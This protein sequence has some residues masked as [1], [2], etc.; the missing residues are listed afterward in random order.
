M[1]CRHGPELAV[2]PRPHSPQQGTTMPWP[3]SWP[4]P[5]H[6]RRTATRPASP[7]RF[8]NLPG[9][10]PRPSPPCLS[11]SPRLHAPQSSS[12]SPPRRP[13][14]LAGL[15][16]AAFPGTPGRPPRAP[17]SGLLAPAPATLAPPPD[18]AGTTLPPSVPLWQF[19]CQLHAPVRQRQPELSPL[20]GLLQ[21]GLG[22]RR[23]ALGGR[24]REGR[25]GSSGGRPGGGTPF[26]HVAA[27]EGPR[28]WRGWAVPR[29]TA[30]ARAAKHWLPPGSP[31]RPRGCRGTPS[32][33][34]RAPSAAWGGPRGIPP[35][36]RRLSCSA[37]STWTPPAATAPPSGC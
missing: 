9:A 22:G 18:S 28:V 10:C 30:A 20:Q 14:C 6:P 36:L 8:W 26:C 19:H 5:A 23:R 11:R 17:S 16:L 32:P 12:P 13:P 31:R 29:C 37:D 2:H 15:P 1:A 24:T 21:G 35:V 3:L 4:T 25:V 34:C 27:E 33:R 7:G